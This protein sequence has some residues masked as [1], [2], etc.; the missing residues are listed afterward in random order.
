MSMISNKYM[1]RDKD[2][3]LIG[4]VGSEQFLEVVNKSKVEFKILNVC[5]KHTNVVLV[6]ENLKIGLSNS[7]SSI[8]M[9][10]WEGSYL[11]EQT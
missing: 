1:V 9:Y 10:L 3:C 7:T 6:K 5:G 8:L 4:V 2:G 11:Y